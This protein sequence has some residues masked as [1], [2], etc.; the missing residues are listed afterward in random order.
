LG[1]DPDALVRGH[2]AWALGRIGG[3]EALAALRQARAREADSG[4]QEEIL[5]ALEE[6]DSSS[7]EERKRQ[8]GNEAAVREDAA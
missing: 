8:G 1:E 4:V 3:D 6:C 5:F 7:A 2:A